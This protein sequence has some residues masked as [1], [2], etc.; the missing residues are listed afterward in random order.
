[1]NRYHAALLTAH[2]IEAVM[3]AALRQFGIME[4][5]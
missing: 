3:V 1:L 2:L 4:R 5:S